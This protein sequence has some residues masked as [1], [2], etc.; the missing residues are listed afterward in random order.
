MPRP[1]AA[2]DE[3]RVVRPRRR[4]GDGE[5]RGVREAVRRADDEQVERVLRVEADRGLALRLLLVGVHERVVDDEPDRAIAPGGVAGGGTD[6]VE[7]VALDPLAGE[8]VRNGEHEGI[9]LLGRPD[10]A[11]PRAVRRVV[12]SAPEPTGDLI[13][14]RPGGQLARL[15]HAW[16]SGSSAR[17]QSVRAYHRS[18]S[19]TTTGKP[20]RPRRKTCRFA[21]S[22]EEI[23]GVFHR[24]GICRLP[25]ETTRVDPA[26]LR[27][28][29]LEPRPTRD[30][31]GQLLVGPSR[32]RCLYSAAPRSA[33]LDR[34]FQS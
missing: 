1:G 7:E 29:S 13:P 22:F 3:E 28:L 24:C 17:R 9:P 33:G 23:Q 14:Q 16:G 11:E 8:V 5:S 20:P 34:L 32:S 12:Q 6:E 4:L 10:V 2:V 27:G 21:G 19:R 25:E 18:E 26:R 31:C 15:L 30:G